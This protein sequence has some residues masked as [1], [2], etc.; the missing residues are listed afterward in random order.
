MVHRFD[1]LPG[2]DGKIGEATYRSR[3]NVDKLIENIKKTGR[4][5][6]LCFAQK[7]DPC[8]GLFKKVKTLFQQV[9]PESPNESNIGVTISPDLPGLYDPNIDGSRRDDSP[10]TTLTALTDNAAIKKLDPDTL[11]PLGVVNQSVLHPSLQGQLSASHANFDPVTGDVYNHNLQVFGVKNCIY[12]VFHTSRKT[13]ETRI[14]A[15]F[16]GPDIKPCYIHAQFITENYLVLGLWGAKIGLGGAGILWHRNMLDAIEPFDPDG[17]VIWLVVDRVGDRGLVAKFESE[18][19]FMFHGA[20]AYEEPGQEPGTVDLI[21]DAVD[22]ANLDIIHR[23]YYENFVS[24]SAG[25]G[26]FISKHKEG[27]N[28]DLTRYRLAGVPTTGD[29]PRPATKPATK[30]F[31]IAGPVIGEFPF[32]NP[33]YYTKPYRYMYSAGDFGK[34]SFMD[35]IIKTDLTTKTSTVW[36]I[37]GHTPGEPVFVRNPDGMEEDDGVLL[38]VMLDGHKG[39]S[40]LLCLDARTMKELGRA[41]VGRVVGMG[42]H[43]AHKK[44]DWSRFPP[45]SG[46]RAQKM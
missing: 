29:V 13:G 35:S 41:D 39:S 8:D 38:V 32:V 36:A 6:Y 40:Y 15:T 23:F 17:K 16:T 12:R 19:R 1:L 30:D 43:G 9:R 31:R 46:E 11:E 33:R 37:D 7:R 22:Y 5:E 25:V 2:S 10:F 21:L 34:S 28:P 4:M 18:N 24:T 42:F 26:D 45:R 20:N 27:I 44:V 3:F 14:L